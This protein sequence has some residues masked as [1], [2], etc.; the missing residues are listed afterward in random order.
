MKAG[1]ELDALIAETVMGWER[2]LNRAVW[3]EITSSE[4]IVDVD[5]W[6]PSTEIADAWL[7][8]EK[9]R[10]GQYPHPRGD[11]VACVIDLHISDWVNVPD[12]HAKIFSPTLSPVDAYATEMPLAICLAALK[13]VEVT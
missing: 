8:V 3:R 6:H 9:F 2:T 10:R 5:Q 7:V 13:A 11:S 1:R 4:H 12:C